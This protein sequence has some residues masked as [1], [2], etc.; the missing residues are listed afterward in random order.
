MTFYTHRK[1][2]I[3]KF[4]NVNMD[5]LY[6]HVVSLYEIGRIPSFMYLN[7]DLPLFLHLF[8]SV[9]A[10]NPLQRTSSSLLAVRNIQVRERDIVN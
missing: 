5:I 1:T 9:L 3:F 7:V 10:F 2:L 6:C 4:M 8:F